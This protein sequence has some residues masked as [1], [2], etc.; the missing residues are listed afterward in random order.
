MAYG[1]QNTIDYGAGPQPGGRAPAPGRLGLVQAFVNS[2]YDIEE[3]HGA[4]L[5]SDSEALGA[6][7]A[8]R[9]LLDA[10]AHVTRADLKHALDIRE[11]LRALL[12]ANNGAPLDD[13]A[14]ARLNDAA[15]VASF[16]TRLALDG[17][18]LVPQS[19]GV[20]GALAVIL[21][22]VTEAMLSGTWWRFKACREHH[23]MWAFFD[24]SRNGAGSWCSMKVCGSRV[25]QRAYY[26]RARR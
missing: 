26:R 21:S 15:G 2:H 10:G 25:K 13:D 1:G 4:D 8:R 11:G 3:E 23:C 7:L 16:G 14:M 24:H 5:L 6:W 20:G 17:P 22:A 19:P 12:L 18:V 9:G